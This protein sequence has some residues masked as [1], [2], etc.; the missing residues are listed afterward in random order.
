MPA[1][2]ENSAV[3]TGLE[4]SA[5]IPV[6]KNVQI[7]TQ[8]HSFHMLARSCSK[9][10]KLGFKSTG[11]NNFQIYNLVL[12]KKQRNERSNWQHPLDHKNERG[13]Q[14]NIYLSFIDYA[15]AFDH[16]VPN[17][18]EDFLKICKY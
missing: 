15:K 11:T 10:F 5:F 3:A 7:I 2:M 4:N 12:E 13:F 17:K 6:P 8:L 16:L 1:N 14:K 18:L 9:S